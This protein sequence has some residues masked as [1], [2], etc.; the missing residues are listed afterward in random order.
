MNTKSLFAVILAL[1]LVIDAF[2]QRPAQA[3]GQPGQGP[4]GAGQQGPGGPH[5]DWVRGVDTNKDGTIDAS[6]LQS[7]IDRTFTALDRNGNSMI[8]G[9]EGRMAPPPPNG[10]Q[11]GSM[12]PDRPRPT[13]RN[14]GQPVHE[15]EVIDLL[16]P[17]FFDK[18][19]RDGSSLSKDQF[20]AAVKGVFNDMDKNH[21]GVLSKNEARP[22]RDDRPD[23]PPRADG[24]QGMPPPPQNAKFIAAELRFGDKLISGQPFSAN[25]VVEDTRRLYDGS[26]VTTSMFGAIY[27]DG[28]GR[29]RREMPLQML[30]APIYGPDVKRQTLIFINDF[31]DRKQTFLD[32]NNKVAR[33]TPLG[34]DVAPQAGSRQP[35]DTKTESLGTKTIGG[36]SVEGTRV[37]F[38]I[39]IGELGNEKPI[40]VVTETW[41][42]PELQVV[43]TSRHVDPIAGEHVFRLENIKR[44]EPSPDLFTVPAGF[45]VDKGGDHPRP[46]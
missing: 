7:A 46:E 38:E 16:P 39:P 17:F 24:E 26:T 37:T 33:V 12:G 1:L 45:R 18:A 28:A 13:D 5:N 29:T 32:V 11:P 43:V 3:G 4:G 20:A 2:A 36:V 35:K 21:D 30:G 40:S 22:P 6:E 42:S 34:G 44:A 41:Y 19:L 27:R 23:G 10:G 25:T 8:D 9:D 15:P 14:A 31:A